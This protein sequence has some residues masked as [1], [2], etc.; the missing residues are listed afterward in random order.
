MRER[1]LDRLL[2]EVV[3]GDMSVWEPAMREATRKGW[4]KHQLELLR[5]RHDDEGHKWDVPRDLSPMFWHGV[6]LCWDAQTARLFA[7]DCAER[8]VHFFEEEHPD[9]MGPREAIAV[10]RRYAYDDATDEELSDASN[11]AV[12]A[13][14]DAAD[15]VTEQAALSAWAAAQPAWNAGAMLNGWVQVPDHPWRIELL[16]KYLFGEVVPCWSES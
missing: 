10:A 2:L 6:E 15:W 7:A 9:D 1:E 12:S 16:E 13:A 4:R 5:I 8:V 14:S 11:W 3:L